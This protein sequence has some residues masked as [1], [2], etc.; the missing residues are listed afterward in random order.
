MLLYADEIGI[1]HALY[2]IHVGALDERPFALGEQ[3][4]ALRRAVG[5]LVV[6]TGE[7]GYCKHLVAFA[8]LNIF[9]IYVVD[10]RFGKDCGY[11]CAELFLR[12]SLHIVAKQLSD[13][14]NVYL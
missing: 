10:G 7:I 2:G 6:L 4:H 1:R 13:V 9:Q 11:G 12:H 14:F 3:L 8:E 5:A